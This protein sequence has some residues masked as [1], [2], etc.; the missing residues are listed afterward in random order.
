MRY[1]QRQA[2]FPAIQEQLLGKTTPIFLLAKSQRKEI[3]KQ[4][5]AS[6]KSLCCYCECQIS[7]KNCHIDHFEE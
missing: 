6:Q 5:I 2:L 7:A 3:V 4:L 1:F